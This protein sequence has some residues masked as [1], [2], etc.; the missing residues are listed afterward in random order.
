MNTGKTLL[1]QVM[2]FLP[3][4][5]SQRASAHTAEV[6]AR[7]R[8]AQL[9]RRRPIEV[10][11]LVGAET[12][13][14]MIAGGCINREPFYDAR[15]VLRFLCDNFKRHALTSA[16]AKDIAV[17][18]DQII[19]LGELAARYRES[20]GRDVELPELPCLAPLIHHLKGDRAPQAVAEA[21]RI[22]KKLAPIIRRARAAIRG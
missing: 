5:T 15:K 12:P 2:D 9:I 18:A 20:H 17:S 13:E 8:R 4:K 10:G 14:T 21:K 22:K 3:W 7:P 19:E 16:E 11:R 1:A 6:G